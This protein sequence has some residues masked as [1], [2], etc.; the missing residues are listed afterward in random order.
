MGLA[1]GA[2]SS[3]TFSEI[4]LQYIEHSTIYEILLKYNILGYVC[5]VDDILIVYDTKRLISLKSSTA[6]IKLPIPYSL[7]WKKKRKIRLIFWTSQ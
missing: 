3:P 5:Y 1:M 2:P 6:S 7:P 4:Y